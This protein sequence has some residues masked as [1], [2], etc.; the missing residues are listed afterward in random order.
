MST[1][2]LYFCIIFHPER[3]ETI[4]LSQ[5]LTISNVQTACLKHCYN[6]SSHL[7]PKDRQ[8]TLHSI[9]RSF[10]P[11]CVHGGHNKTHCTGES[12]I[13]PRKWVV[14]KV[15]TIIYY[16]C[17]G[18]GLWLSRLCSFICVGWEPCL[19]HRHREKIKDKRGRPSPDG[20]RS[21]KC[22]FRREELVS[23]WPSLVHPPK[24]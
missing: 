19:T 7:I 11:R 4:K 23:Q 2:Y 6:F 15:S 24:G 20:N 22:N 16:F 5:L 14:S 8:E 17:N 9:T 18:G 13:I 1:L 10:T 3:A 21:L 12:K